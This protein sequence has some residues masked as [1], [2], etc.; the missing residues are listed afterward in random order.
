MVGGNYR[1]V[2]RGV[3]MSLSA[4]GRGTVWLDGEPR[5]EGD[6]VG[7]YSTDGSDCSVEATSC[8]GI[9]DA[10]IR[11]RLGNSGEGEPD[12]PKPKPGTGGP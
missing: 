3:G 4:V 1:I 11:I 9:P 7:T 2:V 10:Q 5:F 6:D 8:T 12:K